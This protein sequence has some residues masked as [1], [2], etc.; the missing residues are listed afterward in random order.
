MVSPIEMFSDDYYR[1]VRSV[2]EKAALEAEGWSTIRPANH[3]YKPWSSRL[4]TPTPSSVAEFQQLA[5][6]VEPKTVTDVA[7]E[8]VKRGPGRPPKVQE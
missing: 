7:P 3:K 2:E 4:S 6:A 1:V 8:P 5:D